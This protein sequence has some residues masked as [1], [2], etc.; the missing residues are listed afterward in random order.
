MS[1]TSRPIETRK[2]RFTVLATNENNRYEP[3]IDELEVYSTDGRNVALASMRRKAEASG[4]FDHP[5]HRLAH[6]NDGRYGN[7]RSWIS[8]T[9]G[10]GWI[11]IEFAGPQTIDAIVWGRDR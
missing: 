1:S 2:I 9:R 10:G 11:A 4:S 7:S 8:S 3:C 6:V 5:K